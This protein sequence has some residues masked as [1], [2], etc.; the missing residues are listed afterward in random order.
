MMVVSDGSQ[1]VMLLVATLWLPVKHVNLCTFGAL[2]CLRNPAG[3]ARV[4][5]TWC[6][7]LFDLGLLSELH[8][9]IMA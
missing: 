6:V 7:E 5:C 1:H 4:Q 3:V 9:V 2:G 8:G